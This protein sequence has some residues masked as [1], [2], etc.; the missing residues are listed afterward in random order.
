MVQEHKAIEKPSEVL[1]VLPLKQLTEKPICI[2]QWTLTKEKLQT[3]EQIV[4]EQLDA[5]HIEESTSPWNSPVFFI[6]KSLENGEW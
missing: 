1:M 2:K 4:Q 6:K 5:H 3:L